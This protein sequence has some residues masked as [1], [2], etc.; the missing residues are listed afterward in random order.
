MHQQTQPSVSRGL[1][2]IQ[3]GAFGLILAAHVFIFLPLSLY[4]GNSGDFSV[5]FANIL[6][7]SWRFP[8]ALVVL[9]GLVTYLMPAKPAKWFLCLLAVVCVL[10]WTQSQLLVWD[11]GLLD[12]RLIDWS[13]TSW[14]GYVDLAVWLAGFTCVLFFFEKTMRY[15]QQLAIVLLLL[16]MGLSAV[17]WVKHRD[18]LTKQELLGSVEQASLNVLEFGERDNIVHIIADGFQ[19]DIFSEI[20][21]E[22]YQ[23]ESIAALLAGFTY[24][25]DNLGVYPYTHMTIPAILSG[26]LYKNQRTIPE[27]YAHAV[28]GDTILRRAKE[29]GYG[30]DLVVPAGATTTIYQHAAVDNLLPLN[31]QNHVSETNFAQRDAARLIDLALFRSV[32]HFLKPLVYQDQ[33]WL[34]QS[35][36]AR[37]H[38]FGLRFFS[39]VSFLNEYTA[40]ISVTDGPPRYKLIHVMLSHNPMVTTADCEYAGAVLPT[41]R[42]NVLNQARCGLHA[43]LEL[44]KQMKA[45]GIYESSTIIL[46]GDHGAWV[47]PKG[48]R[49][50]STPDGHLQFINP[51]ILALA[52]PMLAVKRSGETAALQAS[53]APTSVMDVPATIA[54][55]AGWQH[56]F[57]GQPV[58][59]LDGAEQRHRM[60]HYYGY[61]RSEWT[62]DYLLPI[63]AFVV[64]GSPVNTSAWKE[65]NVYEAHGKVRRPERAS[66]LWIQPE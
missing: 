46:M 14:R 32:P 25:P 9:L 45:L 13:E 36:G 39:H 22:S 30:V 50:A 31:N 28:G 26:E 60:F 43:V 11:Y 5:S 12:G 2:A 64:S 59:S 55:A 65:S 35:L 7:V 21:Q 57:P 29:A 47:P 23:G 19:A 20:A 38:F 56:S 34:L 63:E 18:D 62:D 27:H 33:R 17:L 52:T 48:M 54:D 6:Q 40:G 4:I 10:S 53:A 41:T 15:A 61:Q 44:F 49:P 42:S 58:F 24:F 16:Q 51:A 37:D 1:R 66:Q 8:A 3:A